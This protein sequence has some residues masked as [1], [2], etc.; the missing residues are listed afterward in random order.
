MITPITIPWSLNSTPKFADKSYLPCEVTFLHRK[1]KPPSTV[2][3]QLLPK[4]GQRADQCGSSSRPWIRA[5]IPDCCLIKILAPMAGSMD[6]W[7]AIEV[8]DNIENKS[9]QRPLMHAS[10]AKALLSLNLPII[11]SRAARHFLHIPTKPRPH[12][13]ITHSTSIVSALWSLLN[14]FCSCMF[15]VRKPNLGF[16]CDLE[17]VVENRTLKVCGVLEMWLVASVQILDWLVAFLKKVACSTML[18]FCR[19]VNLFIIRRPWSSITRAGVA[20]FV[21]LCRYVSF[22]FRFFSVGF[23][24]LSK[25]F[26]MWVF[27]IFQYWSA[28]LCC[29]FV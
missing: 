28:F 18:C 16:S 17:P 29:R 6:A 4:I 25:V 5:W 15:V 24:T 2:P 11:S 23:E 12:K 14:V 13:L 8:T 9:M 27:S 21:Y 22:L 20:A 7:A 26:Y 3:H 1:V 10:L 19:F